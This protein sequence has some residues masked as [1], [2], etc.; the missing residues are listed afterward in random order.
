MSILNAKEVCAFIKENDA[1]TGK[2]A[3]TALENEVKRII[4]ASISVSRPRTT[5]TGESV[6]KWRHAPWRGGL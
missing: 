4:M 3:I 1:R 2:G 6:S 5:V